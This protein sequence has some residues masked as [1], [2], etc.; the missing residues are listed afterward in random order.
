[1]YFCFIISFVSAL[2]VFHYLVLV[3]CVAAKFDLS[4][5]VMEVNE[6]SLLD[7]S[8]VFHSDLNAL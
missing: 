8:C 2:S 6:G 7:L 3:L 1:M 4:D 5:V